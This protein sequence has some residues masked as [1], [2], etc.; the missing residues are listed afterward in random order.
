M[1]KLA[2]RVDDRC[3]SALEVADEVP[4][5]SR[6]VPVV[7]GLEVLGAILADDLDSRVREQAELVDRDVLR[8]DDHRDIRADLILDARIAVAQLLN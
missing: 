3:L 2:E 7:L 4:P 5:E 1:A 6:A 8:R